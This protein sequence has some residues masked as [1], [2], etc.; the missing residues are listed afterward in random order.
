VNQLE[1]FTSLN[2]QLIDER[3]SLEKLVSDLKEIKSSHQIQIDKLLEENG[4]LNKI[5]SQQES[6]L[7]FFEA[8]NNKLLNQL[9]EREFENKGFVNKLNIKEDTIFNLQNKVDDL[10]RSSQRQNVITLKYNI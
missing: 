5:C 8:E 7:K 1:D 10:N 9:E 3:N 6:G 2:T 4:L